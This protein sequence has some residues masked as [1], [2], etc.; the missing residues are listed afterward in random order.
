MSQFLDITERKAAE[1]E[2]L[3]S[4]EELQ[5]SAQQLRELTTH[6][7]EAREN[8]RTGI[9]RE[10]HDQLGQ[11]LTALM[12]DLDAL[13][14]AAMTGEGVPIDR[15]DRMAALLDEMVN[16]VRRIS[17]DLRPGILDDLGLIAAIEWQLDQFQARSGI[18][19]RL[20]AKADDSTLD[21]PRSTALFRVFQ[22]LLTNV[23]R[24]ANA[25]HVWVG[26]VWENGNCILTVSDDGRGITEEQADSA[27]SLGIIGI[28]ERLRPL[29]GRVEFATRSPCGTTVT[30]T[31]PLG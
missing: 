22:E 9:A 7:E 10:L 17:S 3:A 1:L 31:V 16:D 18:E 26:F 5:R 23:A 25:A 19:C 30:V 8:E 13:R 15:I 14:P 6:L 2:L 12:M 28:R 20:V 27:L 21:R 29:G 11:A 4:R 24:H